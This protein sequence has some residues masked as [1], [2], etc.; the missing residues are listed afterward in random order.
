M[1]TKVQSSVIHGLREAARVL[2]NEPLNK[3][4]TFKTGGPA[5]ILA[6]PESPDQLSAV[7]KIARENGLP[8]MVMGGGSNLLVSDAGVRGMVVR[9]CDDAGGAALRVDG[10]GLVYADASVKKKTFI[11]FCLDSG[12]GGVEFMA[13]IPGVLGGG[14]VMNAGTTMGNFVSILKKIDCISDGGDVVALQVTDNMAA[15]RKFLLPPGTIIT[16]AL[17]A[18][19]ECGDTASARK[20]IDDILR[21][22]ESKHPLDY[23][24]AGSVF[25]NPEGHSSWQLIQQAGLKGKR[26][27]GAM[28][29]EKHT[30]F[31]INAGNATSRDIRDLI[32]LVREE[33]FKKFAIELEP[34]VKM[35][36]SFD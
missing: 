4:T 2:L 3:Y 23:P 25:K 6:F 29:S 10:P 34:E 19:P 9:V 15:Y 24:S 30:N 26:V 14:I 11:D 20:A 5:D 22:R 21:D 8:C 13:G 7:L 16:G 28:I 35:V 1:N 36:G 17:Y 32:D 27:G 31:I 18:V 12:Y 33:I